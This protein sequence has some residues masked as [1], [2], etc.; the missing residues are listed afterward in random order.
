M[1][2]G[3]TRG[4]IFIK[5]IMN[6]VLC[7]HGCLASQ[8]THGFFNGRLHVLLWVVEVRSCAIFI[9][10]MYVWKGMNESVIFTPAN[11]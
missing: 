6:A 7:W 4:R 5:W 8:E 10:T 9:I 1:I 11:L 3:T 2:C